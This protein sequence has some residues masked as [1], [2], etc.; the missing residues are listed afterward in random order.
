MA[1][2]FTNCNRLKIKHLTSGL[3]AQG[4]KWA[5][6]TQ[7]FLSNNKTYISTVTRTAIPRTPNKIELELEK[8]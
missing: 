1:Y 4:E 7:N 2:Q 6:N 3:R 8:K 5:K